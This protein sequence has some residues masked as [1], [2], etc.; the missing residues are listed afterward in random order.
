MQLT[1]SFPGVP[2]PFL[3]HIVHVFVSSIGDRTLD[4]RYLTYID[5]QSVCSGTQLC[6]RRSLIL[7]VTELGL[8][9]VYILESLPA[10]SLDIVC[11]NGTIEYLV[12]MEPYVRSIV[13]NFDTFVNVTFLDANMDVVLNCALID[14]RSQELTRFTLFIDYKEI[15][16][17]IIG[18]VQT[19][20]AYALYATASRTHA[21]L[22]C[23]CVPWHS[24]QSSSAS[25]SRKPSSR[26]WK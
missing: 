3:N 25:T 15:V 9:Y 4:P 13:T 19:Q 21:S 10:P 11:K 6:S 18:D 5:S 16:S 8:R 12:P 7:P 2:V 20:A 14:A 23:P 22:I 1:W 24:L 17:Q 26:M